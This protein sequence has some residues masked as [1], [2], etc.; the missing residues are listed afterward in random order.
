VNNGEQRASSSHE[1]GHPQTAP[2]E[3][4]QVER[5]PEDF[6][7]DGDYAEGH[8][9]HAPP[10]D[11]LRHA[12]AID[13]ERAE[14]YGPDLD[15]DPRYVNPHM[16][17]QD[18]D[19]PPQ[20]SPSWRSSLDRG[21]RATQRQPQ[22]DARRRRSQ[23]G[24]NDTNEADDEGEALGEQAGPANSTRL[25]DH[26]SRPEATAQR[27]EAPTPAE[28]EARLTTPGLSAEQKKRIEEN[29]RAALNRK[30]AKVMKERGEPDT[31]T[32]CTDGSGG[33]QKEVELRRCG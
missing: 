1:H 4:D 13:L 28:T 5:D 27:A 9:D 8:R 32:V 33:L 26:T 10:E 24:S 25:G 16:Y 2:A 23:L 22:P 18:D 30:A 15:D 14:L 12:G 31:R 6:Q 3:D 21:G 20:S 29:R 17:P 7:G 19:I 11:D